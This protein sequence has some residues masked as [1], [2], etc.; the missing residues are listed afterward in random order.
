MMAPIKSNKHNLANVI[1]MTFTV[2]LLTYIIDDNID[3]TA[4]YNV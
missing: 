1:C 3:Q 4:S 2:P